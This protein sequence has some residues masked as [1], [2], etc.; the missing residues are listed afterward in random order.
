[1]DQVTKP[2]SEVEIGD[3]FRVAGWKCVVLSIQYFGY[4]H[5]RF[6]FGI[7]P[8]GGIAQSGEIIMGNDHPFT[9]EEDPE[10]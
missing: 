9:V 2:A 6:N 8:E 10:D 5:L 7:G 3:K 4:D 1:M